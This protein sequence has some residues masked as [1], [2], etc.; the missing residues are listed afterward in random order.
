[1]RAFVRSMMP[2]VAS[3]GIA[4][5]LWQCAGPDAVSPARRS[6][7]RLDV[8]YPLV[9]YTG[10]VSPMPLGDSVQVKSYIQMAADSATRPCPNCY[11]ASTNERIVHIT[12]TT[13]WGTQTVG[14]IFAESL[15]T[16]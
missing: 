5:A 9:T 3:G 15:A 6:M 2:L 16:A 10:A 12:A 14:H 1:M 8:T 4:L 11:F 7:H 13:G